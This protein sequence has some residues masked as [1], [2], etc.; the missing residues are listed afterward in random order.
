M[1]YRVL[2]FLLVLSTFVVGC[3]QDLRP[4]Y[5]Q[6]NGPDSNLATIVGTNDMFAGVRVIVDEIDGAKFD[7]GLIIVNA[8]PVK[9]TPGEHRIGAKLTQQSKN[10]TWTKDHLFHFNFLAAHTYELS[11]KIELL[12]E[13]KIR[14]VDKTS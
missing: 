12:K 8:T 11:S 13:P 1:S 2:S 4:K 9:V 7:N 3:A 6:P 14:V 10:S 5:A